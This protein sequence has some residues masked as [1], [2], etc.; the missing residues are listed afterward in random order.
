VKPLV[1]IVDSDAE[2]VP[3]IQM[4]LEDNGYDVETAYDG[5]TA[6][7]KA[8]KRPPAAIVSE[9]VLPIVDGVELLRKVRNHNTLKNVVFI[10]LSENTSVPCVMDGYA[11]GADMYIFKPFRPDEL[12]A[13]VQRC[14]EQIYAEKGQR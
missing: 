3:V 10:F 5:E 7:E 13:F 8:Q 12:L 9:F 11:A 4:T 2:L 6:L 14:I 1:L